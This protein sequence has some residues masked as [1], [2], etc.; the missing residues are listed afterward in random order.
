MVNHDL[1]PCSF[2]RVFPIAELGN[3]KNFAR[4]GDHV[5]WRTFVVSECFLLLMLL[6]LLLL[7][8]LLL[9]CCLTDDWFVVLCLTIVIRLIY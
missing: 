7:L 8:I 2:N 5:R 1:A 3:C 9:S 4:S 6:L